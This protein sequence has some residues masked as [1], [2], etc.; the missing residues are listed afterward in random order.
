[1]EFNLPE[2]KVEDFV[3]EL[4]YWIADIDLSFWYEI[5]NILSGV[6]LF[7][8]T[9]VLSN[10]CLMIHLTAISFLRNSASR[11]MMNCVF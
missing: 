11:Q 10:L 6:W 3:V 7:I 4:S 8:L 2:E 1:M 9:V 5:V